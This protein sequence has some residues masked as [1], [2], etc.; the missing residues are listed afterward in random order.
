MSLK[1][2]TFIFLGNIIL[3]F[4]LYACEI[5]YIGLSRIYRP[6]YSDLARSEYAYEYLE[7]QKI[8]WVSKEDFKALPYLGEEFKYENCYNALRE[9]KFKNILTGRE[10]T[11]L[12][13]HQDKCDGGNNHGI[14]Y[15]D[16]DRYIAKI[17]DSDII[18]ID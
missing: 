1:R 4:Q 6:G 3:S 12:H 18:C 9:I 11:G 5:G 2:L 17:F 16:N 7:L 14:I 8:K 10:F 15:D 13:T